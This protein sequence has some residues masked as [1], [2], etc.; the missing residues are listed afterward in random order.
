MISLLLAAGMCT[1]HVY[2]FK[3]L[4]FFKNLGIM[5][6]FD[7]IAILDLFMKT[8]DIENFENTG[9]IKQI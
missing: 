9:V 1:C 2:A 3:V 6:L 5:I 7:F 8:P 4:E